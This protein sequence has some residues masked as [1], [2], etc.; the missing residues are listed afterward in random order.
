M[1]DCDYWWAGLGRS[2]AAGNKASEF[3]VG[4]KVRSREINAGLVSIEFDTVGLDPA[5]VD[6]CV[7]G[8]GAV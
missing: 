7:C 3:R 4:K 8:K 1:I 5:E 6:A 2:V